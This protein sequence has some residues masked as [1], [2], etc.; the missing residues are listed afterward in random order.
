[1][2][3]SPIVSLSTFTNNLYAVVPRVRFSEVLAKLAAV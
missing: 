3:A 1:M 2:I